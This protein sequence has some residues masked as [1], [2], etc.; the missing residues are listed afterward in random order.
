VR[1]PTIVGTGLA[2]LSYVLIGS[3]GSESFARMR[4]QDAEKG[5]YI[6]GLMVM[7]VAI[8]LTA[9]ICIIE[10]TRMF[11]LMKLCFLKESVPLLMFFFGLCS[12]C[13]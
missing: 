13:Y 9:G 3:T 2:T 8:R 7:R 6:G 5:I 1:A 4:S 11:K 10:G 12:S